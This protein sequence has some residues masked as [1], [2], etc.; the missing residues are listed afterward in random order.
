MSR[1]RPLL[2]VPGRCRAWCAKVPSPC[3][4]SGGGLDRWPREDPGK[5]LMRILM[6]CSGNTCRSPLAAVMLKAKLS[7]IPELAGFSVTSAGTSALAGAPASE[8][9]YLIAI[10]RGLDLSDHRSRLL[11]RDLVK[12]AEL[13][14]TMTEPQAERVASLG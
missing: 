1:P 12:S 10:E 7:A 11:T 6:V 8:G 3:T 14:L 5:L 13:I 2:I 4:S 9:S